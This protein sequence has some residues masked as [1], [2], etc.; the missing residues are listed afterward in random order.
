MNEIVHKRP[1]HFTEMTSETNITKITEEVEGPLSLAYLL[2]VLDGTMAPEDVIF[3]MTTNHIEKLDKALIRPGRIDLDI[4]LTKCTRIQLQ[5]IYLDLY[6][7]E[8]P[9]DLVARFPEKHW[10]T[11]R[12]ILHLFHNSF[13]ANIDPEV[14]IA[15]L[16]NTS[17]DE[18]IEMYDNSD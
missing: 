1:E 6:S 11:A 12:V 15:P 8:L 18:L 4:E 3:I 16:L 13:D 17:E 10:I 2:N 14:L 9:A 5:K 7:K